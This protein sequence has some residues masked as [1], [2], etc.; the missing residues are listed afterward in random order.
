MPS[1]AYLS[2][3]KTR[4]ARARLDRDL[5]Q[6]ELA[7]LARL[8]PRTIERLDRGELDNPGIR[9]ILRLANV[10]DVPV[11]QLVEDEWRDPAW[12]PN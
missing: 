5:S 4:V 1:D 8:S 2:H 10:L 7:S 12:R 9:H 3:G 11:E 6:D